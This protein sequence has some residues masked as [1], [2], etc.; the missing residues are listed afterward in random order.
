[1][2]VTEINKDICERCGDDATVY[3]MDTCAD[4]WGGSYCD[5]HIPRGFRIT[6]KFA[7]K[8]KT[9]D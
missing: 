7:K 2:S 8:D 4:G 3:A 9:T 1:M 6:D 5:S